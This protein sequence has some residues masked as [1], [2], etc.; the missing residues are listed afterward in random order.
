MY[1]NPL[2]YSHVSQVIVF[3]SVF[4][5]DWC[6]TLVC[7]CTNALNFM[8]ILCFFFSFEFT[9]HYFL[10]RVIFNNTILVREPEQLDVSYYKYGYIFKIVP[11]SSWH[12]HITWKA[13]DVFF[14][15]RQEMSAF[16]LHTI[17]W[18][19]PPNWHNIPTWSLPMIKQ[20]QKYQ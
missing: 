3:K 8:C 15:L 6:I 13:S 11:L 9:G 10:T 4:E 5:Q 18:R 2:C 7:Y 16:L 20:E 19:Y 17:V 14:H 1:S 12:W